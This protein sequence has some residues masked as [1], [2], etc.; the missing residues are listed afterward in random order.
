MQE[1]GTKEMRKTEGGILPAIWAIMVAIDIG[2]VEI[3]A[4]Y[5]SNGKLK[6]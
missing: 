6:H 2:L 5:D 4:T 3:Y 1:L